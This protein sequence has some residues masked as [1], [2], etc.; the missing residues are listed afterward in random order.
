M[1]DKLFIHQIVTLVLE[2]ANN[3]T[4]FLI[5]SGVLEYG[6]TQFLIKEG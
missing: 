5:I 4:E 2:T 3:S 1:E 6:H